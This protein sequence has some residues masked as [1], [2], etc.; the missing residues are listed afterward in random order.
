MDEYSIISFSYMYGN[1]VTNFGRKIHKQYRVILKV[2]PW[3]FNKCTT[4][5]NMWQPG[6]NCV[7]CIHSHPLWREEQN[8]SYNFSYRYVKRFLVCRTDIRST[9]LFWKFI[10]IANYFAIFFSPYFPW[11]YR[12]FISKH[13]ISFDFI[14]SFVNKSE[15]N[16]QNK[17]RL[18]KNA[19]EVWEMPLCLILSEGKSPT[20]T[21]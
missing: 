20:Y 19:R 17:M 8:I 6:N 11:R 9:A 7:T 21:S 2:L 1:S 13:H 15:I 16:I 4:L 14:Y 18:A 3:V 12:R 5:Q 10:T